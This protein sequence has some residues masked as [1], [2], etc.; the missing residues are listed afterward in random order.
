MRQGMSFILI[1]AFIDTFP[2]FLKLALINKEN[3]NAFYN[4]MGT[5]IE[6]D[7]VCSRRTWISIA[8]CECCGIKSEKPLYQIIYKVDLP[9]RRCIVVCKKWECRLRAFITYLRDIGRKRKLLFFPRYTF[10]PTLQPRLPILFTLN[11]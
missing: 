9:P 3:Y 8:E 6:K 11:T 1:T 5:Y 7:Y 10:R 2:N 4:Y